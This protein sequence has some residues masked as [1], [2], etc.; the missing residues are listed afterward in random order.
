MCRESAAIRPESARKRA[1][2]G[3]YRHIFAHLLARIGTDWHTVTLPPIACPE[4]LRDACT[5]AR[6]GHGARVPTR[7]VSHGARGPCCHTRCQSLARPT[8]PPITRTRVHHAGA[9]AVTPCHAW[10]SLRAVRSDCQ[11]CAETGAPCLV[12]PSWSNRCA[13][14]SDRST[15]RDQAR[16]PLRAGWL[17]PCW[18]RAGA[19]L[20]APCWLRPHAGGAVL[21]PGRSRV[22][23]GPTRAAPCWLAPCSVSPRVAPCSVLAGSV[24]RAGTRSGRC[25]TRARSALRGA[26]RGPLRAR[27]HRG[28]D[29][30]PDASRPD[31]H[32]GAP[33]GR[34]G[35]GRDTAPTPTVGVG[36]VLSRGGRHSGARSGATVMSRGPFATSSRDAPAVRTRIMARHPFTVA[37]R[38]PRPATDGAS[39]SGSPHA[40]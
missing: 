2:N 26:A 20:R 31:S 24:L 5:R 29:R 14:S 9:G 28:R 16:G 4:S 8:A 35:S 39:V 6:C 17:A 18:L 32:A 40:D 37:A 38:R 7:G 36:A 19:S 10:E 22:G 13:T 11:M 12:A 3:N 23:D 27:G 1:D 25:P 15:T 33:S 34:A 30:A 21:R